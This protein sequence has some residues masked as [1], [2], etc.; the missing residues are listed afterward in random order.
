MVNKFFYVWLISKPA[1]YI[2]KTYFAFRWCLSKPSLK[3]R[4]AN[5]I[6]W[7]SLGLFRDYGLNYIFFRNKTFLLFKIE[8]W[9]FQHLF[10]KLFCEISQTFNSIRQRIEKIRI[11][12]VWISWMSWNFVRCHEIIFQTDAESFSFPSWTP[13]SFIPK[14]Y[15]I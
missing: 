9:N 4:T 12:I 2:K 6:C 11:K 3:I 10:E 15:I 5:T 14:K 1:V 7:N 8:S 13:K